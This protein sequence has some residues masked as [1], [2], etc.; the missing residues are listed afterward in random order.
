MI[1]F[2]FASGPNVARGRPTYQSSTNF[3][4]VPAR[5]VDGNTNGD[6]GGGLSCTHTDSS[7][8]GSP[9]WAVKLP[10]IMEIKTVAITNREGSTCRLTLLTNNL[11][12]S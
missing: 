3:G 11:F 12:S 8:G 7:E 5:A 10:E 4:G 9:W 2:C 1:L 6:Y